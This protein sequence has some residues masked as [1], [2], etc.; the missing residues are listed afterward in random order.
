MGTDLD[1]GSED[2][3]G[4]WQQLHAFHN[5]S[6]EWCGDDLSTMTPTRTRHQPK[7]AAIY[8]AI[9]SQYDNTTVIA[10][11]DVKDMVARL[12]LH[13]SRGFQEVFMID[14]WALHPNFRALYKLKSFPKCRH[15]ERT[16]SNSRYV[17]TGRPSIASESPDGPW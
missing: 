15:H 7:P 6:E 16:K 4:H 17:N 11:L 14:H 8:A 13:F 10:H 2:E 1:V 5:A 12:T 3:A 9:P